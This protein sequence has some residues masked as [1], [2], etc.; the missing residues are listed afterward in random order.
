MKNIVQDI[1]LAKK[2]LDQNE[3]VAIPT[4][5]VYGLAANPFSKDGV[6]KIYSLKNRPSNNPLIIHCHSIEQIEKYTSEFPSQARELALHFW[7]GPLTIL[8]KKNN[9]I[10]DY[11]TANSPY[12]AFRIPNHP[13]T[14]KLLK[15]LDYPLVAPSANPSNRISPTKAMHVY[16]YFQENLKCILDGG[17]CKE[18]IESTIV[19][20]NANSAVILRPGTITLQQLFY[21]IPTIEHCQ[22]SVKN[23]ES[24]GMF[25]KHYSPISPFTIVEKIKKNEIETINKE[26]IALITQ[27]K[28][29]LFL[30]KIDQYHFSAK[31]NLDEVAS[32]LYDLLIQI[33]SMNY[34]LIIAELA[35]EVGIGIAINNRLKRANN[36]TL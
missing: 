28:E 26:R 16:D 9:M 13:L 1:E 32:N 3:L 35:P 11:I 17:E 25:K 23:P 24:P 10:P 12:A 15:Q 21:I 33:D 6:S 36:Y 20:V 27:K 2:I 31:G 5:T 4:E 7:P 30:A 29:N 14:L 22:E 34:D 19:K 18:G 8:L